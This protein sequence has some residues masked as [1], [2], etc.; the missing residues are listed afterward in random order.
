MLSNVFFNAGN[1]DNGVTQ[2]A[3]L[4]RPFTLGMLYDANKDQIIPGVTLWDETILQDMIMENSQHSSDFKITSSDS[5]DTKSNLLDVNA[6]LKASFLGGLI[7]VGGSAKFLNDQKKSHNQ[8]RVTFQYKSTTTFKQ[9]NISADEMKK[10]LTIPDDVKSSATHVVTGIL[11]GANAFFVLD[12]NKVD[13]KTL[14]K[15]ES[16]LQAT[17]NKFPGI[18]VSGEVNIKLSNEEQAVVDTFSCTFY[19]DMIPEKNPTTFKDALLTYVNLPALLGAKKEHSVPLKVWLMPLKNFDH[20][21]EVKMELSTGLLGKVQN[22]LAELQNLKIRCNDCLADSYQF[23]QI[24]KALDAFKQRCSMYEGMPGS[25]AKKI[26]GIRAGKEDENEM[27]RILNEKEQSPFSSDKLNKWMENMER[28]VKVIKFSVETMAG[29][30]ILPK[31]SDVFEELLSPEAEDVICFVFTSLETSDPY[32]DKMAEYLET[33]DFKATGKVSPATEDLWY[34]SGEDLTKIREKAAVIG[35]LSA[36]LKNEAKYRFVVTVIKNKKYKG[37]TIYHHRNNKLITEDFK[38]PD[39]VNVEKITERRDLL[40]YATSLNM[41]PDTA[42]P[43]LVLDGTKRVTHGDRQSYPD[44]H[45]RFDEVYQLLFK[46]RLTKRHYW[47]MKINVGK[48]IDTAVGVSYEGIHRKG[49]FSKWTGIG[50]S[51]VSWSLGWRCSN[52]QVVQTAVFVV[53]PL[54]IYNHIYIEHEGTWTE[55]PIPKTGLSRVGLYLDYNAGSLSYY[56]VR[57]DR[58][59]HI[60]TFH[61]SFSEPVYPCLKM[62]GINGFVGLCL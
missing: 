57:G 7:E 37:A 22:A 60:H 46:E 54:I 44:N 2:V 31:E 58:V 38:K 33:M 5:L 39:F 40:W 47:E 61:D 49:G 17:I 34:D 10:Q 35:E 9:L 19:G 50:K 59:D 16:N 15:I 18:S 21:L 11:Y 14:Q 53:L 24:S 13:T 1:M 42:H 20:Q 12:S 28:E 27:L 41:D 48:D 6:S 43:N 36:G 3:A 8:S 55:K 45:L 56:A 26:P 30:N 4:G 51:A 25:D 32:L 52:R 62:W 23:P 29:V